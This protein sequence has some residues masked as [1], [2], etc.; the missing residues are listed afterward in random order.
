MNGYI[1]I[2]Y[3]KVFRTFLD[4]QWFQKPEMVQLWLYLLLK[5]NHQENKWQGMVI[6]RGQLFVGRNKIQAETGLSE[7]TIKTCLKRLK[8]TGEITTQSTSRG[9]L[10]TIVKWDDFQDDVVQSNRQINQPTNQQSTSDQPTTNQQ[11]TTNKNE[12]NE[13]NIK[14]YRSLVDEYT[15][16][17]DLRKALDDFVSMRKD[18][19]G[20]TVRALELA[21]K[22]L[23][24]LAQD[25][26]TKIMI[27][28]QTIERGWKTFY[29]LK[30]KS[31][32]TS[33]RQDVL[34]DYYQQMKT[35][36]EKEIAEET[37]FDREEF[38][39]IRRQL[40]EQEEKK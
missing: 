2:G 16:D 37:D 39:E 25:E 34:P 24:K 21:L 12:K 15:P 27:V 11:V 22:N 32:Y 29:P 38:E 33:Q 14:T 4:W 8:S 40:R 17:L 31:T 18:M 6:G 7:Q 35:G 28:N 5:A 13:K 9:T 23:D 26:Q 20:F 30:Q 1:K 36:S 3:V 19:N 10:I